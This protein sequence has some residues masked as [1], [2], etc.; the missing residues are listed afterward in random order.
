MQT[1]RHSSSHSVSRIL[2]ETLSMLSIKLEFTLHHR[3]TV[4]GLH[5]RWVGLV[6][7]TGMWMLSVV[8]CLE[9][10]WLGTT[11]TSHLRS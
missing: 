5:V 6:F 1:V 7:Q 2:G 8:E 10:S 11:Q 3:F 4:N 9:V